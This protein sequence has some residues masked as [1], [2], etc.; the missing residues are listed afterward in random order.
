MVAVQTLEEKF[1]E[2]ALMP[3]DKNEFE[4]FME[5][6]MK[7]VFTLFR[8]AFGAVPE[9]EAMKELIGFLEYA[10]QLASK[11]RGP[12]L[13]GEFGVADMATAP[14]LP[15]LTAAPHTLNIDAYPNLIS[16]VN[17][18]TKRPSYQQTAV[19]IETRRMVAEANFNVKADVVR[20]HL[21]SCF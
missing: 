6:F 13:F 2:P 4:A 17:A 21:R 20:T 9:P 7:V 12:F 14:F 1:P 3:Q 10:E 18:L 11:H 19:D 5:H 16:A 8:T 15:L